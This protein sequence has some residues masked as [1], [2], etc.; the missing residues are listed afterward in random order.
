MNSNYPENGLLVLGMHRSGTSCLA[1]MLQLA[2]FDVG[3]VSQWDPDNRK[4]N[5]ENSN[6]FKLN[7]SLLESAG[8][9]WTLPVKVKKPTPSERKKY[10]EKLQQEFSDVGPW[11]LKDPRSLLTLDFWLEVLPNI[12]LIGIFR[13]PLSVA[14]SLSIRNAMPIINGLRL[15]TAYNKRL[16]N[17]VKMC[18]APLLHFSHGTDLSK[19]RNR[20]LRNYF[21]MKFLKER[22]CQT[23]W[24]NSFQMNLFIIH[25]IACK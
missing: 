5:R 10:F 21:R 11:M 17:V 20:V 8:G 15:W 7:T 14:Q 1:G 6:F 3:I 16:L 13:S 4:G 19:L 25:P 22:Y 23:K 18:N 2:G 9:D 24:A 12:R